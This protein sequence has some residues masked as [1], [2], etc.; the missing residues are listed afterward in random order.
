MLAMGTGTGVSEHNAVLL[1]RLVGLHNSIN[2]KATLES[3]AL[4]ISM[5]HASS[6]AL[7]RS[8]SGELPTTMRLLNAQTGRSFLEHTRLCNP[9]VYIDSHKL[10]EVSTTKHVIN[11]H[12]VFT[13]TVKSQLKKS[14]YGM[15]ETQSSN[16]EESIDFTAVFRG[17]IY[18]SQW[19]QLYR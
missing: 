13:N 17:L 7:L 11:I 15:I 18:L 3:S 6:Y 14:L 12:T 19:E 5:H 16:A 1:E 8:F 2:T 9:L 10:L 4:L